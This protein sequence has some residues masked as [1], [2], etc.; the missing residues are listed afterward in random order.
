[1]TKTKK[2]ELMTTPQ[3]NGDAIRKLAEILADTN[4]TEIEYEENGTRIYLARHPAPVTVNATAPMGTLPTAMPTVTNTASFEPT[5]AAASAVDFSKHAGTVKSPMVGTVYMAPAP[6]AAPFIKVG[7]TITAGQTL[8][9]VEAMKVMNPIKA[10]KG[11]TI[12]HI[13]VSDA[14]PVEYDQPLVVVE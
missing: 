12:T 6:S 7:D 4:L 2:D 8:L 14:A 10:P 13:L 1:M 11:G 3:F 9:I 5:P